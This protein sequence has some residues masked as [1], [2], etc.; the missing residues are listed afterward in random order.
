MK[1]LIGGSSSWAGGVVPASSEG[2]DTCGGAASAAFGLED[3]LGLS[4]DA[5][6]L[7]VFEVKREFVGAAVH[8]EELLRRRRQEVCVNPLLLLLFL[9]RHCVCVCVPPLHWGV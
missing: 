5:V 1:E 7:L 2:G 6:L 8:E 9:L 4:L 3:D